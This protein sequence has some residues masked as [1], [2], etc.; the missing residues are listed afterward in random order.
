MS[1]PVADAL[2]RL[3]AVLQGQLQ[4]TRTDPRRDAS[5]YN[6]GRGNITGTGTLTAWSVPANKT[7]ILKGF[8]V[9]AVV[10]DTLAVSG[11]EAGILY[12]L[13]DADSSR[14]VCPLGAFD[15]DAPIGTWFNRDCPDLGSGIRGSAAGADLKIGFYK[16]TTSGNIEVQWLIWGDEV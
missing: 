6:S 1:D 5:V 16:D 12:F 7:F 3:T 13:D 10:N 2:N 9:T 8:I 4:V 14:P 11:G 15:G